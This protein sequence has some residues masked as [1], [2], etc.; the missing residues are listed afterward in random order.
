MKHTYS[1]T[2]MTCGN[3]KAS[4]KEHLLEIPNVTDVAVSLENA[5]ATIIATDDIDTS[6]LKKALPSKYNISEKNI[7]DGQQR[8][9]ETKTEKSKL[10]QLKP[11]FLI[12]TFI[13]LIDGAINYPVFNAKDLMLDFM[14]LFFMVFSLFKLFDLKGFANSFSMY[15]PLA[16]MLPPYG[17]IYPFIEVILG[18]LLLM[19]VEVS[20]LLIVTLVVLII[21]TI[22]VTR[23]L[24]SKNTIQCA[25]LGTVLDL[26]MT[27]ATFIENT[28]MIVMALLMIFS[29]I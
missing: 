21:T 5:E 26:P 20:V 25:C 24:V 14:G 19:R 3:C 10:Q 4:V 6:T 11:L 13:I 15:D 27:E 7:F 28:L 8:I 22:G 29:W 12:F 2:G 9:S 18:V 17:Y 16:K 23:S 1:V